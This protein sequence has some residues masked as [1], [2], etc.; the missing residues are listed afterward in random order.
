MGSQRARDL[1]IFALQTLAEKWTGA[2]LSRQESA[3]LLE[4]HATIRQALHHSQLPQHEPLDTSDLERVG[5]RNLPT[6]AEIPRENAEGNTP[7]YHSRPAPQ[8]PES[9]HVR[10]NATAEQSWRQTVLKV[11][12][13][14][15]VALAAGVVGGVLGWWD[16]PTPDWLLFS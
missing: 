16:V 10:T 15:M 9:P 7:T 13:A 2:S 8:V 14:L 11:L 12:L 6:A 4:S 3:E 1:R 5:S